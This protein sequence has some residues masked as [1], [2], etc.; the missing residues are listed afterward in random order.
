MNK[1]IN[2]VFRTKLTKTLTTIL[3]SILFYTFLIFPGLTLDNTFINLVSGVFG[4]LYLIFL[5]YFFN[6]DTFFTKETET[7]IEIE[8]G[9]T[10][11]DYIPSLDLFFTKEKE[12][13]VK[14]K[15]TVNKKQN[16]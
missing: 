2:K 6:L 14:R 7:K 11:L 4:V 9:E 15:K 10:E 16:K 5:F 3:I 8:P 1:I 12:T 13:E